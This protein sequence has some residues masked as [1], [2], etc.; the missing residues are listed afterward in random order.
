M[1]YRAPIAT[2]STSGHIIVGSGLTIT[3][4]GVLSAV[5]S[6]TSGQYGEFHNTTT[7]TNPVSN[8]LNV[9][10]FNST[11]ISN[12]VSI[13]SGT[14]ITVTNAGVYFISV[15]MQIAKPSGSLSTIFLWL[16]LNGVDIPYSRRS[17]I[18]QGEGASNLA[19][20][21]DLQLM[22]AGQYIELVWQTSSTTVTLPATAPGSAPGI[23][24][25][26]ISAIQVGV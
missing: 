24:S 17:L 22:A 13:V 3:P 6:G 19:I 18:T 25:V 20:M 2:T 23:P 14:R 12:G 21:T 10:P 11:Q 9:I 26:Q 16:R 15:S 1:T 7:L 4:I 8:A 5:S